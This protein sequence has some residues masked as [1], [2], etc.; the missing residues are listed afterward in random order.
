MGAKRPPQIRRNV[1]MRITESLER[2]GA[3]LFRWRS[4]LPL[5]LIP[6]LIPALQEASRVDA[7]VG[8]RAHELW[9]TLCYGLS[10]T[11]LVIRW[12][13]VS[14]AAP[15]TSGRNVAMQ[16]A[17]ALNTTGVYS[18]V[19]HP[20][21]LGNFLAILGVAMSIMVW[22]FVVIVALAY[23][24]YIERIAAAEE[25]FLTAK[26]GT[27]YLR[28]AERTP[29]F[30]PRPSLWQRS[31]RPVAIRTVLKREYNGVLSL[32]LAYA[33]VEFLL[34]VMVEG[35]PIRLWASE[36]RRWLVLLAISAGAFFLLRSLKKKTDVLNVA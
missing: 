15:G 30:L 6:L 19:R 29:A 10:V 18:V 33:A 31:D 4:Y 2:D 26:F 7:L 13:V 5:L 14:Q 1:P 12:W 17:D 28:W 9:A 34:D 11:G 20:L 3:F 24:L 36:D 8:D 21:Y 25:R 23:W 35:E 27:A 32:A 22:W 16:R